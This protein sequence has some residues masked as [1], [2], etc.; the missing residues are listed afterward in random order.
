MTEKKEEINEKGFFK[1]L[2]ANV[3]HAIQPVFYGT[4]GVA[5]EQAIPG[6]GQIK[7]I[8]PIS[9][10][11]ANIFARCDQAT[12]DGNKYSATNKEIATEHYK[13]I[14]EYTTSLAISITGKALAIAKPNAATPVLVSFAAFEIMAHG[15]NSP[16]DILKDIIA[17]S[18]STLFG[19]EQTNVC[20]GA[21]ALLGG[22]G[23]ISGYYEGLGNL[24]G[25]G[26]NL[27]PIGVAVV[28]EN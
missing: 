11:A 6:I 2:L 23:A 28:L 10:A 22:V 15:N 21:S 20:L 1:S 25:G 16:F 3:K 4:M 7:T 5:T 8:I 13:I 19:E 26:D 24:Q 27:A 12:K 9:F 17:S 18:L 14:A